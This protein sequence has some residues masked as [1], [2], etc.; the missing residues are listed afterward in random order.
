MPAEESSSERLRFARRGGR[1]LLA[2]VWWRLNDLA[3]MSYVGAASL[4]GFETL[5]LILGFATAWPIAI[6]LVVGS[7]AVVFFAVQPARRLLRRFR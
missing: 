5:A 4:V 7:L 3:A 1:R 2:G 6:P